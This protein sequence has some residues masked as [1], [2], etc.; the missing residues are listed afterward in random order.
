MYSPEASTSSLLNSHIG[1]G[2]NGT[3]GARREGGERGGVA[4]RAGGGLNPWTGRPP[5]PSKGGQGTFRKESYPVLCLASLGH[6]SGREVFKDSH[7]W[8]LT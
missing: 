4:Y 5:S 2:Q 3:S 1:T 8:S 6:K 7:D